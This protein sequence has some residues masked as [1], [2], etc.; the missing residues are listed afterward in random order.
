MILAVKVVT[1]LLIDSYYRHDK[2]TS[3]DQF[4]QQCRDA[5]AKVADGH[6]DSSAR[7]E[8]VVGGG[9]RRQGQPRRAQARH[10]AKM[11]FKCELCSPKRSFKT[12]ESLRKHKRTVHVGTP[13]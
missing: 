11:P 2:T 3:D 4:L 9:H 6:S 12:E 5:V 10:V 8:G 1:S 13:K 7:S